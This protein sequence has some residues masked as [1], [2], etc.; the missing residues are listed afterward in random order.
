MAWAGLDSGAAQ[1]SLIARLLPSAELSLD[2]PSVTAADQQAVVSVVKAVQ[3]SAEIVAPANSVVAI[4]FTIQMNGRSVRISI[5]NRSKNDT[6][7]VDA[8]PAATDCDW[9]HASVAVEKTRVIASLTG[10]TPHHAQHGTLQIAAASEAAAITM[11][12]EPLD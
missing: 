3:D 9:V 8:I 2:A 5:V 1:I 7:R 4:P 11:T 10:C 6:P 12:V